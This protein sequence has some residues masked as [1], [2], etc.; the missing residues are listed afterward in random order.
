MRERERGGGWGVRDF[1][2]YVQVSDVV[3][4]AGYKLFEGI[5]AH[6]F[7]LALSWRVFRLKELL[8]T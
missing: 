4:F 1:N 8:G 7:L 3:L 2:N 6:S 5:T